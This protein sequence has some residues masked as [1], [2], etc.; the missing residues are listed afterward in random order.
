M[1]DMGKALIAAVAALW[2]FSANASTKA[3][4]SDAALKQ[5]AIERLARS[6]DPALSVG[7]GRV[8][9]KQAALLAAREVL[10]ERGRAAGLTRTQWNP[11]IVQWQAAER[12]L[13]QG[14]DDLVRDRV[15]TGV[16]VQQAWGEAA[17]QTL[18]GEEADEIAVHF[19][20]EGGQLQRKVIEWFVGELT[21]QTYTFTDRLKYGVPGSEAEMRDLQVATYERMVPG[22][23]DLTS[24]PDAVKFASIDPG[25]KYFKMMV[26]QGIHA[27]HVYL[28]ACAEDARRMVRGRASLADPYIAQVASAKS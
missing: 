7:I 11:Q 2:L 5:D 19:Q 25:V 4:E 18:N 20:S 28:E 12:E 16:W 10:A 24:Y 27:V 26:M 23:Y 17:A 1:M 8:Y 21:L 22:I 6:H 9:V 3:G 15:A 14:I 13:M